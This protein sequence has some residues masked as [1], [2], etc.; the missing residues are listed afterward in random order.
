MLGV[1]AA[2]EGLVRLESTKVLDAW[3]ERQAFEEVSGGIPVEWAPAQLG[4][5]GPS[6]PPS[7]GRPLM[8][9]DLLAT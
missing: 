8:R 3:L 7:H 9:A 6:P 2:G 5:S 1:Q 4:W